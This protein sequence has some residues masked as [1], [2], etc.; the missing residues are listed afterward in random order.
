MV[1]NNGVEQL[2]DESIS[3]D[4]GANDDG[5]EDQQDNDGENGMI[6]GDEKD[7]STLITPATLNLDSLDDPEKR[8]LVKEIGNDAVWTLSSA[9]PGNG[10][11]QLRDSSDETYWQSDG[12]LPHTINIYF[13]RR[14]AV[15]EIAFSLDFVADESY[16][17]K[18]IIIKSGNTFYDLEEIRV[19]EVNEPVGWIS[20]PL[21]AKTDPLDEPISLEDDDN[22]VG[23]ERKETENR[24]RILRAH[25]IQICIVQNHQNGRDTHV[26]QVKIFGPRSS[27]P[28]AIAATDPAG[29]RSQFHLPN[30]KTVE[31][32][33][34]SSLR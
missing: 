3:R 11:S 34:F 6:D 14:R 29:N 31:L 19:V 16:T 9:K 33:Q 23:G 2:Q 26:R 17:P 5:D 21:I 18:K 15:T 1:V 27:T 10:I 4:S 20:V 28:S 12:I 24:R 30:F 32:S 13:S 25:L 22:L 8:L 7:N